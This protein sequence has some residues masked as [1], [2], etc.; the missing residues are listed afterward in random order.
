M[1]PIAVLIFAVLA[2]VL[3]PMISLWSINTLFE[4]A[5]IVAYIPHNFWTYLAV[6]ALVATFK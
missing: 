3:G 4:Q 5:S 6:I 1:K 2:F